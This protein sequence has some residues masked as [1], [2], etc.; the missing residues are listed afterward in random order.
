MLREHQCHACPQPRGGR[1]HAPDLDPRLPGGGTY[2]SVFHSMGLAKADSVWQSD[3][4]FKPVFLSNTSSSC[5]LTP[6]RSPHPDQCLSHTH[7]LSTHLHL[8][9]CVQTGAINAPPEGGNSRHPGRLMGEMLLRK[10]SQHATNTPARFAHLE[11]DLTVIRG[12]F[13]QRA[14][15]KARMPRNRTQPETGGLGASRRRRLDLFAE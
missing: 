3:P 13:H 8:R 1:A 4:H 10:L 7:R 6:P 14:P 5:P 15:S 12:M 9:A 11:V 2:H